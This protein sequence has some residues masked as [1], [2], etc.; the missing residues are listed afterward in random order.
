[1]GDILRRAMGKKIQDEMVRMKASFI[2]GCKTSH[3]IPE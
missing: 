2:S 1:M 3:S